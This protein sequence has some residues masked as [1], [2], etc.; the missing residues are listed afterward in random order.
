[1]LLSHGF[2]FFCDSLLVQAVKKA[3][4]NDFFRRGAFEHALRT[5]A[6]AAPPTGAV[7]HKVLS[8]HLDACVVLS[9]GVDALRPS[10]KKLLFEACINPTFNAKSDPDGD[11]TMCVVLVPGVPIC[12]LKLDFYESETDEYYPR[13]V[14]ESCVRSFTLM[15]P[16]EY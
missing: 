16:S 6:Y 12:W 11:H 7:L 4:A 10:Q 5:Q 8:Q 14:L 3:N 1:M 9:E 2:V 13:D 15:F